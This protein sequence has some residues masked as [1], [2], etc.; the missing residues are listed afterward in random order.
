[1][2]GRNIY[3]ENIDI[4]EAVQAYLEANPDVVERLQEKGVG[5]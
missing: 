2:S 4:E 1:M 5:S 3:L